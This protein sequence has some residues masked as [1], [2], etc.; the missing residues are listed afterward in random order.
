MSELQSNSKSIKLEHFRFE[1]VQNFTLELILE[2]SKYDSRLVHLR[3]GTNVQF[4]EY[5]NLQ[6]LVH[7]TICMKF[8]EFS[9]SK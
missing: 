4:Q 8:F 7:L 9:G 1:R 5:D 3:F 2:H 6:G